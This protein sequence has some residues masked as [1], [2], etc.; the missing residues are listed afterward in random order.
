[1]IKSKAFGLLY[2][3]NNQK[4]R[5]LTASALLADCSTYCEFKVAIS[6]DLS[7]GLPNMTD[8]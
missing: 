8:C 7:A 4:N 6:P 5:N 3:V 1:M 2:I